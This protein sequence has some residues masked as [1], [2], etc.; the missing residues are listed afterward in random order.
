MAVFARPAELGGSLRRYLADFERLY[1]FHSLP[2]GSPE[3]FYGMAQRLIS[4]EGFRLD[5]SSLVRSVRDMN[6][7]Q[8]SA[9]EMLT[10]AAMAA[11]GPSV[12]EAEGPELDEAA[13]RLRLLLAGVGGWRKSKEED[14]GQVTEAGSKV[15]T[16]PTGSRDAVELSTAQVVLAGSDSGPDPEVEFGDSGRPGMESGSGTGLEAG[17]STG[18]GAGFSSARG[19]GAGFE[20][21]PEMKEKLA[22]LEMASM[23]LKVYLDDIDRR[24]GRIE[25]HLEGM[26]A[27]ANSS[28]S[29]TQGPAGGVPETDAEGPAGAA[30]PKQMEEVRLSEAGQEAGIARARPLGGTRGGEPVLARNASRARGRRSLAEVIAAG[31]AAARVE[32]IERLPM[33]EPEPVPAA[34]SAGREMPAAAPRE[35]GSIAVEWTEG[36]SA[37]GANPAA[38]TPLPEPEKNG[39]EP[40]HVGDESTKPGARTRQ[41]AEEQEDRAERRNGSSANA[42]A[43]KPSAVR[44]AADGKASTETGEIGSVRIVPQSVSTAPA[45]ELASPPARRMTLSPKPVE[46]SPIDADPRKPRVVKGQTVPSA[47]VNSGSARMRGDE[48]GRKDGVAVRPPEP[49][50]PGKAR[51][52]RWRG[53]T[54]KVFGPLV[55]AAAAI[56]GGYLYLA[57]SRDVPIRRHAAGDGVWSDSPKRRIP[58][59][60]IDDPVETQGTAPAPAGKPGQGREAAGGPKSS[61]SAGTGRGRQ[62]TNPNGRRGVTAP[63]PPA[64]R[65]Q[66]ARMSE[67][68]P[69]PR[70]QVF[71]PAETAAAAD[72]DSAT[73][74]AGLAGS[75]GGTGG[76]TWATGDTSAA[77]LSR[78]M[79]EPA[80]RLAIP[81]DVL[82]NNLIYSRP[83]VYPSYARRMGMEGGVVLD[84]VVRRD[85]TVQDVRVLEGPTPFQESAIEAVRAWR[86]RPYLV[87]GDAVEVETRITVSYKR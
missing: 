46:T 67:A 21:S 87:N 83:P 61:A 13:G 15:G 82:A 20:V 30:T 6:G 5:L 18:A 63:S 53:S 56:G 84:A 17:S 80:R 57:P 86:Y 28:V 47:V 72:P 4:N 48:S 7:G 58:Q 11:G 78:P 71:R 19:L 12:V 66:G 62:G 35:S 8:V 44:I 14:G 16:S 38:R 39:I 74:S 40:D 70:V 81:S 1:R 76:G 41:R 73:R 65:V 29:Q 85:G 77:T 3:D 24:I 60:S 50:I 51:G 25:P 23:Q 27:R 55:L 52:R 68:L 59:V 10:L 49:T 26:A 37:R 54:V 22:R 45:G 2:S 33:Q 31:A 69:S 64:G 42:M 32:G 9:A 43:S 79:P 75:S 34:E 36:R